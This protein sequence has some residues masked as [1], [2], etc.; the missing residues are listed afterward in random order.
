L[1]SLE[2]GIPVI[3]KQAAAFYKQN[4]MVCLDNQNHKS[5]VRLKVKYYDDSDVV[6]QVFWDG[7]MTNQLRQAYADLVRA[8]ENAACAMALLLVREITDFTAIQQA[9]RGTT[10]DYY[11]GYK[12]EI[13]DL[14]FNRVARLEVSGILREDD[15]N[16]IDN[17]IKA[18]LGRLKSGL[19]AFI[20]VV[21]FSC[22]M[23]KVAKA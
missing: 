4:C 23:C 5:G 1:E 13:D 17:R 8:T 3:P 14:I 22:P 6:F 10:I 19:P 21:E 9:V 7:P 12:E 11:L 18:K 16:T 2:R 20:F 15:S